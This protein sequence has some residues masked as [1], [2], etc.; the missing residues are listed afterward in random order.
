M[1]SIHSSSSPGGD[2]EPNRFD[3]ALAGAYA[4][5]YSAAQGAQAGQPV[6]ISLAQVA[7]ATF[8]WIFW[9]RQRR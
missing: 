3:L 6:S 9:R 7:L 5:G 4:T 1:S 8:C 2:P